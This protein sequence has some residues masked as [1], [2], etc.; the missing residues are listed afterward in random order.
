MEPPK[1]ERR[2]DG[3]Y[4]VRWTDGT[5]KRREKSFGA[6]RR[7][8]RNRWLAWVNQ[9][10]S[11]PMVRDPGDT[12][13]LTVAL[14]VERYEA[15]AATYY[16]GSRE[17]L[18]IR[19]TL[20]A[21]VEVAGDTLASEI[22]P[23]TIDAYRELQVAR[24]ISLGV[25]N[26]R[27]R[28]IRRAWKWL[29]SKRLVSIESWQC[30]CALEPLRRGRCAARVTEPVRPVAD[31]VVE[32]TCDALPPSIAAMV[33]LQRITGMRPG[34]VCAMEWREIDR[35]GEV[36]V[37][38]PR[39][40]KTAHHGHRRR[41][42]L[43]PRAQAILAPLV[44]LAI[45]GRVFSPNLAMEERDEAARLAYEPPEGAH[46]YRTWRCY[47]SRLAARPRR[48]DRGD[49]WT[50]V[51]YAQAIRRAAQAAGEPHWS[52][53]QLRHSAATEARRGGGLDVAQL[54]LGHRHAEVTEVYAETD[55]ARLRDWVRRH[56]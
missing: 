46:D 43:G 7:A 22:G 8:A 45:G 54:L 23:E 39:H 1:L 5:G 52:P 35:S 56:G 38:E 33:R 53:N 51:S 26:Q 55:L 31:S 40:H 30:L 24:D 15:H 28:T 6:D 29:A 32:R 36:W 37:Y 3:Y 47:Q 9:W 14:A 10:R 20:R 50:T 19:H 12:G 21:L 18:N 4:R 42:M 44:G 13:P 2:E 49:E 48:H 16:A 25:I 41:V 11:D 17:V 34:E 27:V